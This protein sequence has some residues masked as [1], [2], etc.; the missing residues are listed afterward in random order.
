MQGE[1]YE[2]GERTWS[3]IQKGEQGKE[4]EKGERYEKEEKKLSEMA[5]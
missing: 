5:A 2:K 4:R 1:R 3:N